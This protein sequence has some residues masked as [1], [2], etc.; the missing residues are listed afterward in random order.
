MAPKQAAIILISPTVIVASEGLRSYSPDVRQ[1]FFDSERILKY[2][3]VYTQQNCELECISNYTL[4]KCGCVEFSMASEL[5][6]MHKRSSIHHRNLFSSTN[7]TI[8]QLKGN[9]QVKI[10]GLGKIQCSK[11]AGQSVIHRNILHMC[12]CLP[13]CNSISYDFT[14]SESKFYLEEVWRRSAFGAHMDIDK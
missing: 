3:R 6:F 10:C 12:N 7:F 4:S 1:C 5:I 14:M 11:M 2:F 9:S 13:E 8:I